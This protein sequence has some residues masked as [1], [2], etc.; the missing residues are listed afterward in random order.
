MSESGFS[1]PHTNEYFDFRD[2]TADEVD[3]LVK[4]LGSRMVDLVLETHMLRAR[5]AIEKVQRFGTR[6]NLGNGD[7]DS[8]DKLTITYNVD[9]S[10]ETVI[11]ALGEYRRIKIAS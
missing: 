11:A 10:A 3:Y 2:L 8:S 7:P 1:Y 4:F 9:F 5:Q 6:L